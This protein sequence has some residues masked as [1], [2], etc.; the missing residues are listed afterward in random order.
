LTQRLSFTRLTR[1]AVLL[2]AAA[3]LAGC[4]SLGTQSG[5]TADLHVMTSGGF[6]AAYNE[7]RPDSSSA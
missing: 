4:G 7:L 3:V 2:S 5:S 6:T 1:R